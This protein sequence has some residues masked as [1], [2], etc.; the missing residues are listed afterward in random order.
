V[1][2]RLLGAEVGDDRDD[3]GD[4]VLVDGDNVDPFAA[5]LRLQLVGRALGDGRAGVDHHD[6]VGE[7]LGLFEVLRG[8]QQGGAAADE[9]GDDAPQFVAAARVEAGGGL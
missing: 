3:L 6:V 8:E 1:D 7:L 2:R 5:D 4:V 9:I